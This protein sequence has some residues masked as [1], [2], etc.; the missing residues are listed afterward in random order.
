MGLYDC[1]DG[2]SSVVHQQTSR[3]ASVCGVSVVGNWLGER[4]TT[5][6]TQQNTENT[7][8]DVRLGRQ[9]GRNDDLGM[10]ERP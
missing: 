9:N 3:I 6:G 2:P 7:P 1:V 10:N 8:N 4:G 5:H